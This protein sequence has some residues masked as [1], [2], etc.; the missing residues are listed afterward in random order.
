MIKKYTAQCSFE[1]PSGQRFA[2]LLSIDGTEVKP[3]ILIVLVQNRTRE[4]MVERVIHLH[5]H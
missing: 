3:C 2:F 4:G 5:C 1:L